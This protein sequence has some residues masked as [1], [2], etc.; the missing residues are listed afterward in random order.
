MKRATVIACIVTCLIAFGGWHCIQAKDEKP[1]GKGP[2]SIVVSNGQTILLDQQTGN[3][4]VLSAASP[5][6][7]A[8]VPIP[9]FDDPKRYREWQVESKKLPE[10]NELKVKEHEKNLRLLVEQEKKLLEIYGE[11][12]PEV[13]AI[14]KQIEILKGF[15]REQKEP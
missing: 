9:R 6:R 11:N 2:F 15:H 14:R 1:T 3:T 4:W 10:R 7:P 12:H 8:W 13:K 5:D